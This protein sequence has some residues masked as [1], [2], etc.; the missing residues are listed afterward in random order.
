MIHSEGMAYIP[1]CD[2]HLPK[3]K[4]DAADC[5]PDGS[6]DP[7]NV[8]AIRPIAG[9]SGPDYDSLRF[10]HEGD[11]PAD[12]W[13]DG[14]ITAHHP[15]HGQ[16]G[17]LTYMHA[18]HSKGMRPRGVS[19]DMLKVDPEHRR[20]G[21]ASQLMGELEQRHPGLPIDHGTRTHQGE[22]WGRHY[23]PK[24]GP[25]QTRGES[26]EW[27]PETD[28]YEGPWTQNGQRYDPIKQR[29]AAQAPQWITPQLLLGPM[30]HGLNHARQVGSPEEALAAI[31]EGFT[32][33]LPRGTEMGLWRILSELGMSRLEITQHLNLLASTPGA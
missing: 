24:L 18:P 20:R 9:A 17:S 13:W 4:S 10:E 7:S 28:K 31:R 32:A 1:V 15:E 33:V 8:N 25:S 3:G 27:A 30:P 6:Y 19:V 12:D 29:R 26:N 14:K 22:M 2:K 23:Y 16:V 5:T 21:V 11:G